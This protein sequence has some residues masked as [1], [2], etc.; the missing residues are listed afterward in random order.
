MEQRISLVTLGVADLAR[1]KKFYAEG[2]GWKPVFESKEIVFFQA[3]GMIFSLFLRNELAKDFNVDPATLGQ[4]AI[5]LAYNVRTKSDVD[6]LLKQAAAAGA[7]ILKPAKEAS[8]GG[9]SGYFA[10]LD[11]FAWEVAWNPFWPIAHDGTVQYRAGS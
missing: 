1:A 10:D 7:K 4:G 3:G 2:L 8:W 6:P 9:Y 5:A 11:G